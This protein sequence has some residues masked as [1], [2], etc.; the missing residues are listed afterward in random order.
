MA[1]P[2]STE[3][4]GQLWCRCHVLLPCEPLLPTTLPGG[5][6][7]DWH[8]TPSMD[9]LGD[10]SGSASAEQFVP[11]DGACAR[12]LATCELSVLANVCFSPTCAAGPRES[13]VRVLLLQTANPPFPAR[14]V[15]ASA[16]LSEALGCGTRRILSSAATFSVRVVLRVSAGVSQCVV[17]VFLNRLLRVTL[18]V[19]SVTAPLRA[20][21]RSKVGGRST[22]CDVVPF[23]ICPALMKSNTVRWR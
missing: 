10:A 23:S 9:E 13:T 22:C 3:V 19:Y 8:S 4:P 18:L 11:L 2:G 21:P 15:H 16:R 5:N 7:V 1:C 17:P 14:V 6:A 12:D 20:G